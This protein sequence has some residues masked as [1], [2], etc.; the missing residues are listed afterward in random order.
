MR[1]VIRLSSLAIMAL[2]LSLFAFA[3]SSASA[4]TLTV[5]NTA[6]AGGGSLR[7]AIVDATSNA[8]ANTITFNIPTTDPGYNSVTNGFTISLVSQLPDLPLA[9][10][11]L[12]NAMGRGLTLKGN[13]TFRIFTLV[14]S[15]VVNINN[16]TMTQGRSN[17]GLGGGIYMGDSAVLFLTNCTVSNNTASNGGGGI[18]V[19]D[20]GTL[21]LIDSTISGNTTTTGNGGGIFI[22]NSGTLN[23]TRA[24]VNGNSATV[25]GGGGI[26]NGTS[27][28]I[29]ATNSTFYGNSAGDMGGGIANTATATV[30][31]CTIS[32]NTAANGGGG[33]Y[34]NFTA[35][36]NNSLIAL[37]SGPDGPDLL[38]RGSRG[39][40]FTGNSNLIGNADGSE[41]FGP[42]TNQLGSTGSPINPRLGPLQ[43]NGGATFTQ[44]LLAGSPAI[45]AGATALATD[46]RGVARPKDGDGVGGAQADIGSFENEGLPEFTINDVTISE[47]GSGSS[48]ATFTVSLSRA[49]SVIVSVD[50]ATADGTATQGL[51]YQAALGTLFFAPGETTGT[52]TVNILSDSIS[53]GPETFSVN[54]RN[55]QGGARIPDQ[56]GM[57]TIT[58]TAATPTPT[59][60]PTA[61]PTA[62]PTPTPT[63]T[64]TPTPTATPTPTPTPNTVQF[65]APTYAVGE[66]DVKVTLTVTR[67]GDITGAA[68]VGFTTSD[69]SG[70]LNC[71]LVTGGA[72]SRCDYEIRI[73]TIRFAAGESS[74]TVSVFIIDD[75]YLEGL[76]TFDVS[77]R[78]PA[79]AIL[80]AQST[81]VV[82]ITDNEIQNGVNPIDTKG[83]F[84]NMHYL[85]FLN[86]EAD[87]SGFNFWNNEFAVCGTDQSCIND[88]RVN[89]SAAFYLSIEFQ[90]TGYLVERIYK[91]AYGDAAGAST[92]GG[93]HQIAVPVVRLLEFLG[94]TQDISEGVI[95]GQTGWETVLENNKQ[96]LTAEFVQSARFTTAYPTSMSATAFVDTLNA[97]AGS[98]LTPESRNQ[99]VSDLQTATKTRAQ[100]LRAVAEDPNLTKAEFNRAFVLM[101]YFGYLRRNPDDAQDS[102]HTGY[103]FWL[104]KMNQFNGDYQKAEMVKA[105]I[106][107]TEYRS[108]FGQ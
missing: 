106:T 100:V 50:F 77:L 86:R 76:E 81:A 92:L 82:A 64:P 74:K 67:S 108:R 72:S 91:T 63:A 66:G 104:T 21:H 36:L 99:L 1:L 48:T 52:V 24:T 57:G 107:S 41:A 11:T 95:V 35:T 94:A 19:N 60:T 90:Q 34:N 12:D 44:A 32:G 83:F 9:P 45:D 56:Q 75:Q 14:N 37:N 49:S 97:N 70:A 85:D 98:P 30:S 13:N 15:A 53:E 5:S 29:N 27:G 73:H 6:D 46:Q 62:T 31:S 4:A 22:N 84:V 65:N 88:K 54:L 39:K 61:T 105:F 8:A 103:D 20:S 2:T 47:P 87:T 16:M 38:G 26:Y 96:T 69:Q 93:S 23:I 55:A 25:G 78:N 89:V 10:L 7:Q 59:P 40:P 18:W 42:T 71:N 80:G 3:S 79:G 101:Q 33:I 68:S 58:D 102:D 28:T 51:D 17:G 43:D